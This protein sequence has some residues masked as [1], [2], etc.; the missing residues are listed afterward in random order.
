MDQQEIDDELAGTGAQQLLTSRSMAR[1]AYLATDATPRVIPIGFYVT[2]VKC[3]VLNR[4]P[5]T[6]RGSNSVSNAY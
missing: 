5:S 3:S 2:T 1:L 6:W 4:G